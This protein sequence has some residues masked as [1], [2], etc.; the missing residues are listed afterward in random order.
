MYICIWQDNNKHLINNLK[1]TIKKLMIMRNLK[2]LTVLS[3]MA[4]SY[5]LGANAEDEFTETYEYKE[6]APTSSEGFVSA[7]GKSFVV[8]NEVTKNKDVTFTYET[9]QIKEHGL[10]LRWAISDGMKINANKGLAFTGKQ[11]YF[12]LCGLGGGDKVRLSFP[13]GD[14]NRPEPRVMS[15]NVTDQDGNIIKDEL[16]VPGTIYTIT[17]NEPVIFYNTHSKTTTIEQMEIMSHKEIII[18]PTGYATFSTTVPADITGLGIQA[19]KATE[20]DDGKSVVLTHMG[21]IIPAGTGVVLHG[22]P[23]SY[24]APT[25]ASSEAVTDG[26]RLIATDSENVVESTADGYQNYVLTT[27][28]GTTGFFKIEPEGR[29]FTPG[30]AYLQLPAANGAKMYSLSLGGDLTGIANTV[31][32]AQPANGI[33]HTLSGMR[34]NKPTK[35]LYIQNGK[36]TIIK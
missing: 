11:K 12:A 8:N 3:L 2:K 34:V 1:I 28:N 13:V 14:T 33:Y 10:N 35:G 6:W 30:K 15:G 17:D 23:G 18:G 24:T 9:A 31:T 5:T 16:L 36:K 7:P 21:D 26:N 19:C 25:T 22:N 29:T 32:D 27:H 20:G 4:L